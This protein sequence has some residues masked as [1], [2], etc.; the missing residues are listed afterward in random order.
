MKFAAV[1][2]GTEGDTRPMALLCRTLMDAGHHAYLLADTATLGTAA[3]LGVPA[4]SLAGNMRALLR[5]DT[6]PTET[7]GGFRDGARAFAQIATEH[8][9]AWLRAILA[10]AKDCDA[11]IVG[12]LAAFAGF[13]AAEALGIPA[14]GTGLIPRA[15]STRSQLATGANSMSMS[16]SVIAS[17]LPALA[18]RMPAANACLR[19]FRTSIFSSIV[20]AVISR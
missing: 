19:S 17:V 13:S 6:A 2:Y 11:L 3:A 14:I 8:S 9:E 10:V 20:P 18:P 1:T 12:D 5:G 16:P 4:G 15:G 7:G